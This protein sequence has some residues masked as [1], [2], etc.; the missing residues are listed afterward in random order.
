MSYAIREALAAFRRTPL[1]A[2]LSAAMIALSL[3]V[4][5][6]FGIAAYN[7]QRVIERVE[8]SGA[9]IIQDSWINN[10]ANYFFSAASSRTPW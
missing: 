6:L 8:E 9:I 10:T 5:G 2:S 4:L 7:T 1:L 3:F